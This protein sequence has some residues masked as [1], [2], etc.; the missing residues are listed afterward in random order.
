MGSAGAGYKIFDGLTIGRE[1]YLRFWS[2]LTGTSTISFNFCVQD[3]PAAPVNDECSTAAAITPQPFSTNCTSVISAATAGAT[4]SLP[5]PSCSNSF[6]NDDIWYSFIAVSN[7]VRI[8]FSNARQALSSGNANIGYALYE[9]SCPASSTA[10]SCNINI[11]GGSG[12]ALIA[13]LT[14]GNTYYLSFFSFGANNYMTF[15]FCLQDVSPAPGN[16]ECNNAAVIIP[17][18]SGTICNA[19]IAATTV[20]ATQSLPD[21]SCANNYN[22]DDIWYSFVAVTNGIRI[23]FSNARQV[24]GS[25]NANVGYALYE[26]ELPGI[27]NHF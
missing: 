23:N 4:Q 26:N 16:D 3:V 6:N 18:S 21:P 9:N 27:L 15:D 5:D 2:S 17:Q 22:N 24:V 10:F 19:P 25:G 8:S 12:S 20:G 1:Y 13:G 14:P 7:I 11:G